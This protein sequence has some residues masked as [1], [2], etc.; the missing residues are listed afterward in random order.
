MIKSILLFFFLL[1]P[2]VPAKA[3]ETI[4]N[5]PIQPYT[6]C[7]GVNLR[8]ANL[9]GADLQGAYLK[10]A[11]LR[12][13]NLTGANLLDAYLFEAKL[14]GADLTGADLS[15]AI[16]TDGRTCAFESIGYCK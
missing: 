13:A 14:E 5:C 15:K 6:R 16:W 7:P 3:G 2:A 4:N 12:A 11:D 1:V 10:G 9:A 8:G